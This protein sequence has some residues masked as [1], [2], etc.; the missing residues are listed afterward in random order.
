MIWERQGIDMVYKMIGS[1]LLTLSGGCL[2]L[3]FGRYERQRILVLDGFISL[4]R[5]IRGQVDC[6]AMPMQD[7]LSSVDPSVLAAC[8]GHDRVIA[9]A[10]YPNFPPSLPELLSESRNFLGR[11]S[12]RL[13]SSFVGEFG[14]TFKSEQVGRCDYYLSAL[15]E[16]RR[17]LADALPGRLRAGNTLC[18]SL[19]LTAAMLLW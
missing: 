10:L 5:F 14:H 13:L 8:Q 3:A 18:M 16:E 17:R 15:G 12:E 11:E 7:I 2:A 19:A 4:L 9:P 1:L 6:F